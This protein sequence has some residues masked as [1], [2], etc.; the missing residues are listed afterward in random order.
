MRLTPFILAIGLIAGCVANY[1]QQTYSQPQMPS[2][3][4]VSS[5][6][7]FVVAST[8]ER[9]KEFDPEIP[10]R[11]FVNWDSQKVIDTIPYKENVFTIERASDTDKFPRYR[12]KGIS[13]EGWSPEMV[14]H[15]LVKGAGITVSSV[16]GV[17]DA[18]TA[19]DLKGEL[20]D[21]VELVSEM[22]G[23][24]YAYDA[25]FKHV[26]LSRYAKWKLTV[27]SE[28]V[29]IVAA[30]DILR[31][32]GVKNVI[33]NWE[34]GVLKFTGTLEDKVRVQKLMESFDA[35]PML[36]GYDVELYRITTKYGKSIKWQDMLNVFGNEVVKVSVPGVMGKM[37]VVDPEKLNSTSMLDFMRSR[38]H[39][40]SVAQ[41]AFVVPSEW[42][43]RFN[44]GECGYLNSPA[45]DLSML[46]ETEVKDG[47][48]N[49]FVTLDTPRGEITRFDVEGKIGDNYLLLGIPESAI[50]V[51]S[52]P[53]SEIVILVSPR[54]IRMVKVK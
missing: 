13:F 35:D 51:K 10:D 22:S 4:N 19:H 43:G 37:L 45:K 38:A 29:I 9:V 41:G 50:S 34:T 11:C 14:I 6:A 7:P 40:D 48:I 27:P 39:V 18:L 25:K 52:K 44:I 1:E 49:S 17:Y 28:R 2:R 21:V 16:G 42:R 30:L 47:N 8:P 31:G 54:L 26:T 20:Q 24:Q 15:T 36:V 3:G 23:V 46:V 53:D 5:V 32:S 12:V 33:T